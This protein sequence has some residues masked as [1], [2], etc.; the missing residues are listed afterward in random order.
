MGI[1]SLDI[2]KPLRLDI[3]NAA[4]AAEVLPLLETYKA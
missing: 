3:H 4:A 2:S 1:F